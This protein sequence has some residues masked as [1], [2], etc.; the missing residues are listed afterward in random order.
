MESYINRHGQPDYGGL[1]TKANSMDFS[2]QRRE[3]KINIVKGP[4][5][6]CNGIQYS[7]A[8]G[9]RLA[10]CSGGERRHASRMP[11]DYRAEGLGRTTGKDGL[12]IHLPTRCFSLLTMHEWFCTTTPNN[13][14][15]Y[16]TSGGGRNLFRDGT[17]PDCLFEEAYA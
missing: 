6:T 12:S 1:K 2:Q 14:S 4:H 5:C 17:S 9:H 11:M 13:K 7:D 15:K 3:H 16:G 8:A 10:L